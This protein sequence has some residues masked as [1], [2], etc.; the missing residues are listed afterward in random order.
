[1]TLHVRQ[2]RLES[3]LREISR[4]SGA[5][6]VYSDAVVPVELLVD[7]RV[8]SVGA[9]EALRAALAGTSLRVRRARGGEL[10]IERAPAL[11]PRGRS[12]VEGTINGRVVDGKS[13]EGIDGVAV[14]IE[15]LGRSVTTGSGGSFVLTGIPAGSYELTARR[16]GFAKGSARTEVLGGESVEVVITLLPSAGVLNDVVVT[17][18]I[19]ETER[20]AIPTAITV[21]TGDE[22]RRQNVQRVDQLFR[23]IVPGSISW[24]QGTNDYTN[25][26]TVRG[27]N[28]L[29][30]GQSYIKTY[31]DGV[32]V[33]NNLFALIDVNSIDRI[34]IIR[35]PQASTVYGSDAAGGVMQ[36]FTKKGVLGARKP[37]IDLSASLTGVE[38]PYE[39][40][41][42]IE[43]TYSAS[44]AGGSADLSYNFGGS[45]RRTGEWAPQYE[46]ST[47][48]FFAGVHL[49]QNPFSV[50][51]NARYTQRTFGDPW[52]TRLRQYTRFSVPPFR[53]QTLTNQTYGVVFGYAPSARWEHRL[54][55]GFDRITQESFNTR[56]RPTDGLFLVLDAQNDKAS[57][58]YNTSYSFGLG[59]AAEGTV[60]AGV[61]RFVVH[62]S[63]FNTNGA[64]TN[65]G[66]IALAPN[67]LF[68]VSRGIGDNTGV[69]AQ[70]QLGIKDAVF[71][72]AG[73]RAERNSSFGKDYGTAVSPRVGLTVARSLGGASVKL[74]GAYGE[75]IR[76]PAYGVNVDRPGLRANTDLAPE[77]QIG[78][79]VGVDLEVGRWGALSAT[80]YDQ[81][82]I[83]LIDFVLFDATTVPLTFQFQ[84]AARIKNRGWELETRLNAG[85]L[86]AQGQFSV[87]NSKV[88][89]LHPLYTGLLRVGDPLLAV[90]KYSGGGTLSL[91]VTSRTSID[92]SMTYIGKWT[93]T[94]F[95]AFFGFL[96]GGEPFRGSQR[97]YW[98]EY[99]SVTKVNLGVRQQL[100]QSMSAFLRVDNVADND[101]YELQNSTLISGRRITL[102]A[103]YTR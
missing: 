10:L 33:S 81:T 29:I 69:F 6:V 53:D 101:R 75:A 64:R 66:T 67:Q 102:G 61:E 21:V 86:S 9:E 103:R 99:P 19:V 92:A 58:A 78:R 87:T 27:T 34:E 31:V 39:S 40:G 59:G 84:N 12:A 2:A 48:S 28:T 70:A 4:Q 73:I 7:V 11:P 74:R 79:E 41:R 13:G 95:L 56:P 47:P 89:R 100:T 49:D 22:L 25:S 63:A 37:A 52:D 71:L 43:Q 62:Q 50:E 85:R 23:T 14:T 77:E 82:A 35:G 98:M 57:V 36:I 32:E 60:T 26:I 91:N 54:T 72:T 8:E 94:D 51:L 96:F 24:D 1:V 97:A 17:G 18:S 15:R 76:P 68:N 93:N 83:S 42:A 30:F 55:V 5:P 46:L 20:K 90:P 44:V 3:V 38:S 88:Q 16:I 80:F 45:Y 65:I